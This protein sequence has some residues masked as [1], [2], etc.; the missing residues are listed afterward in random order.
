MVIKDQDIGFPYKQV[1]QDMLI[2][3]W[4]TFYMHS[5]H[6]LPWRVENI[7]M[8]MVNKFHVPP[9]P[10]PSPSLLFCVYLSCNKCLV[11][12][13]ACWMCYLLYWLKNF[14]NLDVIL[15]LVCLSGL[16]VLIHLSRVYRYR[17]NVHTASFR[18]ATFYIHFCVC[19]SFVLCPYPPE[20]YS[21]LYAFVS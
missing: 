14:G 16:S 8:L 21:Y 7:W 11:W 10:P 3:F 9:L 15:K 18:V 20:Y 17:L 4:I 2:T 19:S 6:H 5:N 12:L 1:G 13:C